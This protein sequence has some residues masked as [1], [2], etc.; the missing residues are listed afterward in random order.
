MR[1]SQRSEPLTHANRSPEMLAW[2]RWV[3]KTSS[4]GCWKNPVE[5]VRYVVGPSG[6]GKSH[7]ARAL[8]TAALLRGTSARCLAF[9]DDRLPPLDHWLSFLRGDVQSC[10]QGQAGDGRVL[11]VLDELHRAPAELLAALDL[12]RCR[13][14]TSASVRVIVMTRDAPPG[15][16][17]LTL[18]PLDDARMTDL[19]RDLGVRGDLAIADLVRS[20]RGS[21]GWAVASL[22]RVP[23]AKGAVIERT[24][25]LSRPALRG[26]GAIAVAGG[27]LGD[28]T[29]RAVLKSDAD[30]SLAELLESALVTRLASSDHVA[31]YA[32]SAPHAAGDVAEAIADFG[33]VDAVADAVL[34]STS[35]PVAAIAALAAAPNPPSRRTELLR[36]G[37]RRARE[38]GLREAEMDLLFSLAAD[39]LERSADVL[40]QLERLTR[41]TGRTAI[42][43]EV[44]GWLAHAASENPSLGPLSLRRQAEAKARAG[45]HS[46]AAKLVDEAAAAATLR[47]DAIGRALC[48]ATAGAIA[49]YRADWAEAERALSEARGSLP[50]DFADQEELARVEHN[51]G[52]VALYRDRPDQARDAFTRSLSTKRR[53]GDRAGIRACLLNLGIT[54]AKLGEL[55]QADVTLQEAVALAEA[56]RQTAGRGWCLAARA[57]VE[58][59]RKNALA[60]ERW[61]AEA[62]ALGDAIPSAV[63]ADLAVLRASASLLEGDGAAALE[64][65]RRIDENLRE[66][67]ALVDSRALTT[68]ARAHLA[69]LPVDRKRAARLAIQAIRRSRAAQLPE[70]EQ[71]AIAVLAAARP[72]PKTGSAAKRYDSGV[73]VTPPALEDEPAWQWMA[74]VG[75]G[76]SVAEAGFQLASL[77]VRQSRAERGFVALVDENA[78]TVAA[79][80]ADIDGLA[81]AEADQRLPAHEA[82]TALRKSGSS[83][84]RDL[85]TPLGIGSRVAVSGGSGAIRAVI[86]V[87]HRFRA[88]CFDGVP[89]AIP[90]R[91]ATL[92]GILARLWQ[93]GSP[94]AKVGHDSAIGTPRS[95]PVSQNVSDSTTSIPLRAPRR[96]FPTILGESRGLLRALAQLDAAID[97]D[98]PVLIVGETGTGKELFA[99]ALHEMGRRARFPYVAVNCGAIPEALF[100]A[101]FFGHA[102]GSFTGAERARRGLLASSERGT[103]LL[104]EVGELPAMR[105]ASLLARARVQEV[106]SGRQ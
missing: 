69:L 26:L 42:H 8:V 36:M 55:D 27:S 46:E 43:P 103:L 86:I 81:V 5:R 14:S 71:D 24:K 13:P 12:Y 18:E 75:E 10:D 28:S 22:G 61:I 44:L 6:A 29:L 97:S 23:L 33:V 106:Q 35:P 20:S 34:E 95:T 49:L 73:V 63:R 87:E 102:R 40:L 41:D 85:E 17:S 30:P 88:D 93:N 48:L 11:L 100:E 83:Y 67:D 32:L 52:V 38:D 2:P 3:V 92:A 1:F 84:Y 19:V 79:W 25:G 76:I 7:L 104:D 37:I 58:V 47:G 82:T 53:L 4:S 91:W 59:R 89:R 80:G 96:A 66:G 74:S 15:A 68:E 62:E 90:E 64:A 57:D 77:A 70:A 78:H 98:L 39:P 54:L 45:D 105:Q 101:E 50:D 99:R 21:P 31:T 65:V 16:A 51:F 94:L 9:S 56:L 60:A 72:F